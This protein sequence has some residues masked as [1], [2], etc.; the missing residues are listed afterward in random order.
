[1]VLFDK[2]KDDAILLEVKHSDDF[3]PVYQARHLYDEDA[4]AEFEQKTGMKIVGKGVVYRGDT[5][6]YAAGIQYVS[7]DAMLEKPLLCIQML[8]NSWDSHVKKTIHRPKEH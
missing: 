2:E 5:R 6:Y 1:M 8:Q 4:C 3:A 7:V